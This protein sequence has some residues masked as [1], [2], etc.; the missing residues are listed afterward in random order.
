MSTLIMG[1]T[2]AESV[3]LFSNSYLAMRVAY[4]NEIDTFAESFGLDA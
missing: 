4:F 1:S 3:K 2:E